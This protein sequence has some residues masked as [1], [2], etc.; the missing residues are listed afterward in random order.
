MT[1]PESQPDL[2]LLVADACTLPS[3]DRPLRLAEFDDLFREAVRTIDRQDDVLRLSLSGGPG[4]V[5]RVR[6]LAARE[7]TCCS[8]FDFRVSGSDDDAVL[9][10][11]VPPARRAVLDALACRASELAR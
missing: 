3:T 7:A 2:D 6:D 4:L 10:V 8:F 9:E 1:G 5:D 11:R